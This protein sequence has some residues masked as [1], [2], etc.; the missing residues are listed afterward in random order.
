VS[1]RPSTNASVSPIA[2]ASV[3][4]ATPTV[5]APHENDQPDMA[6]HVQLPAIPCSFSTH[7]VVSSTSAFGIPQVIQTVVTPATLAIPKSPM[8]LTSTV[9]ADSAP[10]RPISLHNQPWIALRDIPSR[11]NPFAI[12]VPPIGPGIA[13]L[14]SPLSQSVSS[15]VPMI[16]PATTPHVPG[17]LPLKR[18][19]WELRPPKPSATIPPVLSAD[20]CANAPDY[21][22]SRQGHWNDA[23]CEFVPPPEFPAAGIW[24]SSGAP[25]H[26]FGTWL[27][28]GLFHDEENEINDT[29]PYER[30]REGYFSRISGL[31]PKAARIPLYI[32]SPSIPELRACGLPPRFEFPCPGGYIPHWLT[33][34]RAPFLVPPV[35]NSILRVWPVEALAASTPA[36]PA[37]PPFSFAP[38]MTSQQL[39]PIPRTLL[40]D[41]AAPFA[42]TLIVPNNPFRITRGLLLI[43]PM[44][45][46]T[47]MFP[48]TWQC[49]EPLNVLSP[50]FLYTLCNQPWQNANVPIGGYPCLPDDADPADVAEIIMDSEA[51]LRPGLPNG[52]TLNLQ[53]GIPAV[54]LDHSRNHLPIRYITHNASMP[55]VP[56]T[57][58]PP[59]PRSSRLTP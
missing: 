42:R 40:A 12:L 53:Q 39:Q 10:V 50:D 18:S 22:R 6:K 44:A 27:P 29:G 28:N 23:T 26:R 4:V 37:G 24:Y 38:A 55:E 43:T 5:T 7:G 36:L 15:P 56:S 58:V 31:P 8:P 3:L 17:L 59:R 45:Q 32:H 2:P 52:Y 13:P 11:N 20:Y 48:Y 57:S 25:R 49:H 46:R 1:S 9:T 14:L 41:D 47:V 33:N 54:R 19:G 21:S 35:F 51:F 30:R 34:K 16:P